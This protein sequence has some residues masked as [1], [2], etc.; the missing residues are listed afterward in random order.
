MLG[1]KTNREVAP[2]T[3]AAASKALAIDPADSHANSVLA[4]MAASVDYDWKAAET[5]QGRALA[6]RPVLPIVRYRH[7][8]WYL[9]PLGRFD[10][11]VEEG[12]LAL[13]NDPLSAIL[14]YGAAWALY[15]AG[16]YSEAIVFLQKAMEINPDHYLLW[17]VL[18]ISQLR[19]GGAQE[20]ISSLKRA[21]ELASWFPRHSV[22]SGHD[23]CAG[24][25][26]RERQ[27]TGAATGRNQPQRF[28]LGS[29]ILRRS[30]VRGRD[31]RS[32][33]KERIGT[34]TGASS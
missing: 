6:A 17:G 13:E 8:M 1:I 27:G 23:L 11:A 32:F 26:A 9:L 25:R 15:Y 29:T 7:V 12:R 24:G 18:G 4:V 28:L 2:L 34:A 14:Q 20:A 3:K 33:S 31:V 19:S 16:K 22:A 21:T 10:A 5:F 30:R